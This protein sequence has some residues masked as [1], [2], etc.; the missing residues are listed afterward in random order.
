MM[1]LHAFRRLFMLAIILGLAAPLVAEVPMPLDRGIVDQ[2]PDF[3][4]Q[5]EYV[6]YGFGV[7]VMALGD[8]N[9]R[10]MVF[11]GGLPGWLGPK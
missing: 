6:G 1:H 11:R 8:H 4:V 10:A 2:D 3:H 9:F 5:G 7:Q